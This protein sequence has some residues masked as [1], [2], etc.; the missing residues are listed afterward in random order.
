MGRW[1]VVAFV[2]V[3]HAPLA[4]SA[5]ALDPG[6]REFYQ[7]DNG[8]QVV[9]WPQPQGQRV[10]VSV[11]YNVGQRHDPPSRRGLAHLAEHLLFLGSQHSPR[12]HA[13]S[14]E[15][16][17]STAH[18]GFVT[19]DQTVLFQE[20]PPS[21]LAQTLWLERDRMAFLLG[22]L[23]AD[24][25]ATA[26][27]EI[28]NESRH[29]GKQDHSLVSHD[30]SARLLYPKGHPYH[31]L[32]ERN[33]PARVTLAEAQW[34]IQRFYSPSNARLTVVGRFD[35]AVARDLIARYFG[36]IRGYHS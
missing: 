36:P 26:K 23:D 5:S 6:G 32:G 31:T 10:A 35:P 27:Q 14:I 4:G 24:R 19:R 11:R 25:L 22:R 28:D 2:L 33:R 15:E 3:A 29:R 21:A 12:I 16:L 20:V 8:L 7:L 18:N 30:L 9:L 1:L 13:Q 34:F 17:G